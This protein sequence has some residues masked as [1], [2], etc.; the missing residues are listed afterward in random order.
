MAR[1]GAPFS[2]NKHKCSYG[3]FVLMAALLDDRDVQR[4]IVRGHL[5]TVPDFIFFG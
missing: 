5:A 2:M 4:T 1:L 3:D